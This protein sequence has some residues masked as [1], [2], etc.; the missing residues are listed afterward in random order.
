VGP[1]FVGWVT[2]AAGSQRT[3]M[4]TVLPFFVVGLIMLLFVKEQR[5]EAPGSQ[6]HW[7]I[8]VVGMTGI[9]EVPFSV[10]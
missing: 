6:S 9:D 4:A 8:E 5:L 3:G 2:F 7:P 10:E 1:A